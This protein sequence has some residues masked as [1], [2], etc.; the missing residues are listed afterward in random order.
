MSARW[1]PTFRLRRWRPSP[2]VQMTLALVSICGMLLVLADVLLGVFPDRS[3]EQLRLR[4]QVGEAFAVQ[5]AAL[6]KASEAAALQTTLRDVVDRT[7]GVRSVGL[8]RADGVLVLQAGDHEGAWRAQAL[9]GASTADRIDV[10]MHADGQRWGS[11]E[12]AFETDPAPWW[13]RLLREPLLMTM[14]F[15]G[16]VGVLVFGLYMRRALQH[17]DPSQVIPE[18]V[19]G[20]FDTMTE[21]VVVLDARGRVLLSNRAFRSLNAAAS[22]VRAGQALSALEWLADGLSDNVATHPWVRAMAERAALAGITLQVELPDAGVQHLTINAAPIMDAAGRVRGCIATFSDQTELQ[23]KN[24]ALKES[25]DENLRAQKEIEQKN[26]ELKRLATRDPMTGALN[27]RA[28]TESYELLF[29]NARQSGVPLAVLVMDIDFFKKVNDTHGH[30]VGDR[31]IQAVARV[32]QSHA[33]PSDLVCRYGGEEFVIAL[34]GVDEH[35]ASAVAE[36]I[37]RAVEAESGPSVRE[38]PGMRVTTSI[39]VAV[40]SSE[41]RNPTELIDQADQALYAAKKGGRN[42][43]CAH[44]SSAAALAEVGG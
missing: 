8:R 19:Q 38:V 14:L 17:L 25:L 20:A 27:R 15:V 5:V 43:V 42:R 3:G 28:F 44:G 36:R 16:S 9:G 41:A 7:P 24:R 37:R 13:R 2:L 32:A 35:Q 22:Q 21:G 40:I 33:R 18:R 4:K 23:Q 11:F 29:A 1:M 31:V 12:L 30:T 39:G 34:P 26:E 6:L 10:P